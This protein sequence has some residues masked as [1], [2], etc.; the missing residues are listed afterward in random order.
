M[1]LTIILNCANESANLPMFDVACVSETIIKSVHHPVLDVVILSKITLSFLIP[2]LTNEQYAVLTLT[3]NEAEHLV[4]EFSKAVAS[5][6]L[7]TDDHSA[8]E[9]L[10]FFLNFT[11]QF[12]LQVNN[13]QQ[14]GKAS[15]FL[16]D[17]KQRIKVSTSNIQLLV[18][19]GI[20]KSVES[21]MIK[22]ATVDSI[23]IEKSLHLLWNLIHDEATM[24]FISPSISAILDSVHFELSTCAKSLVLCIQ[25]SIGG[26]S[27]SGK[28]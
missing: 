13:S 26:A 27:K 15:N 20:L 4:L 9:L 16:T 18:N 17:F 21:L 6:D 23:L 24:K 3:H 5:S 19:L 11:K 22:G 10:M 8:I 2:I 7:R 14:G 28:S 25:W 1:I 12:G